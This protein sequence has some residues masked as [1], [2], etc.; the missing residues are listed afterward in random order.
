MQAAGEGGKGE[1]LFPSFCSVNDEKLTQILPPQDQDTDEGG[2]QATG[3][4][5][6][7]DLEETHAFLRPDFADVSAPPLFL[8]LSLS[9]YKAQDQNLA[10]DLTSLTCAHLLSSE[11]GTFSKSKAR[12]WSRFQVHIAET[13]PNIA[14]IT[15]SR[16]DSGP[17]LQVKVLSAFG[18]VPSSLGRGG[19]LERRKY[20]T[21]K[22]VTAGFRPLPEN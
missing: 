13:P 18:V 17:G 11:L 22:T 8:S 16:P 2:S 1:F 5:E 19:H 10:S 6:E 9:L 15:R 7:G 12:I 20:G 21:H 4:G 3:E 14:H